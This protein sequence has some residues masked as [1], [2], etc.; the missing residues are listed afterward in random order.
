MRGASFT[1]HSKPRRMI[2][3]K[4]VYSQPQLTTHGNVE[5][6]TQFGGNSSRNDVLFFSGGPTIA[7]INGLGSRD[8]TA[9]PSTK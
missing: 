4:K 1:Q 3:M 8:F 7:P 2:P 6:I 5:A 9:T